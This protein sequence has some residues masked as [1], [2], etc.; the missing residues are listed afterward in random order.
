MRRIIIVTLA[1]IALALIALAAPAFAQEIT[2]I[3]TPIPQ[4]RMRDIECAVFAVA[5]TILTES[6]A[7]P[8]HAQRLRLA[9]LVGSSPG[10][11]YLQLATYAQAQVA[12]CEI[13]WTTL[14]YATMKT[15]I[16]THWTAMA[17]LR[18]GSEVAP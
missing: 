13:D 17:R 9:E 6:D 15:S 18:F 7:T 14:P 3:C 4:E 8:Y 5:A 11:V 16:S 12:T 1:L 10:Q 2:P